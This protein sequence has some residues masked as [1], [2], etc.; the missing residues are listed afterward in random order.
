M[1]AT[2]EQAVE[3]KEKHE[4][5]LFD[6][7]GVIGT[8]VSSFSPAKI[9]VYVKELTPEIVR[10]VPK[11]INGVPTNIIE[12]GEVVLLQARTDKWRPAPAGVSI[13]HYNISAGTIGAIVKDNV[14]GKRVILSNNHILA[15]NDS[16]QEQRATK[17]DAIY[18]PGD[19][20]GGTSAD[21]IAKLERWV[22]LNRGGMN[23]VDCAIAM[24]INDADVSN[25]ILEIGTM[26]GIGKA[27]EGMIVR[28]CGRTTGLSTGTIADINMTVQVKDHEGVVSTYK[29]QIR[30]TG[31]PPMGQGG[32]SG[33]GVYDNNN[34][35]V[36]LL[37]AGPSYE[38]FN[39]YIANR[40]TNVVNLLNIGEPGEPEPPEPEPPE[41]LPPIPPPENGEPEKPSL[42]PLLGGGAALMAA[43]IIPAKQKGTKQVLTVAALGLVGYGLYQLLKPKPP[44]PPV[45]GVLADITSFTITT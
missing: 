42:T 27:V 34:K 37:F 16:V 40:I 28:Y 22:K 31:I 44:E 14:S 15:N 8:G 3:V 7:P 1:V 10:K 9:N 35:L 43:S 36:G 38:P 13:G 39:Y 18:Q 24:P 19:Y 32:D 33:S 45:E 26:N 5:E 20:D 4:P 2:E 12:I 11:E 30:V 23:A 17:G 21:T 25:E 6:I 41:P 29:E